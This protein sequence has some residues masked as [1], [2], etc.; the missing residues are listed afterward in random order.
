MNRQ[1]KHIEEYVEGFRKAKI[2]LPSLDEAKDILESHHLFHIQTVC[3]YSSIESG[4]VILKCERLG[5]NIDEMVEW[6]N[7]VQD[8]PYHE[9][10]Q[11]IIRLKLEV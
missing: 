6:H 9:S 11:D 4:K 2:T 5:L 10:K 8:K 1:I 3:M 7:E